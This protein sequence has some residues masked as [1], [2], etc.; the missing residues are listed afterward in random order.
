VQ[1]FLLR[2]ANRALNALKNDAIP[3]AA[4]LRIKE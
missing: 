3:G 4:V 2:D 1:V